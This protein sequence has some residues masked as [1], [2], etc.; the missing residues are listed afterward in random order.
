MTHHITDEQMLG[1]AKA[2][3]F[4]YNVCSAYTIKGNFAQLKSYTS[5]VLALAAPA[6]QGEPFGFFRALP[7]GWEQCA[8]GDEGAIALYTAP[9]PAVPESHRDQI[10]DLISPMSKNSADHDINFAYRVI[11]ALAAP[12]QS[13]EVSDEPW[14]GH[15]FKEICRG[16]W[17]CDCG[18][19]ANEG[20][21][22]C[23]NGTPN[24]LQQQH[25]AAHQNDTQTRADGSAERS[26]PGL[27]TRVGESHDSVCVNGIDAEINRLACLAGF[28]PVLVVTDGGAFGRFAAMLRPQAVPM[29]DERLAEVLT[30]AYGSPEWTM[31]DVRAARAVEAAA[32]GIT[33]PAG[34]EG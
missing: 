3:G 12:A 32:L 16:D 21:Q 10:I 5:A 25:A 28:S 18:K 33:A 4:A 11:D 27:F 14:Y 19:Q 8:E 24:T 30:E 34:V 23:T 22:Q 13:A 1:M 17:L 2:A 15:R 31:A 6:P 26:V 9:A 20:D 7:F 29:T